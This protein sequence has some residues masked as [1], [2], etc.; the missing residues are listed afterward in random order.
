M[1]LLATLQ[2]KLV[3]LQG[4]QANGPFVDPK[5]VFNLVTRYAS[6]AG[7]KQPEAFFSDPATAQP[8]PEQPNPE[9]LKMQAEQ[10]AKQQDME[11]RRYE[12]DKRIQLDRQKAEAEMQLKREEMQ[13]EFELKR[14]SNQMNAIVRANSPPQTGLGTVRMGGDIG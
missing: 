7:I 3:A 14:Q 12:I 1:G 5:N 8:Q 6:R 2:E 13:G 9:M 4:G 11:L 10:A